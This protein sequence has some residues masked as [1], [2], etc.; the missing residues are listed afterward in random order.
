MTVCHPPGCPGEVRRRQ[1]SHSLRQPSPSLEPS[2][3]AKSYG[4]VILVF[5]LLNPYRNSVLAEL[6]SLES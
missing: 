2:H 5:D 1:S 4:R 3:R 6:G